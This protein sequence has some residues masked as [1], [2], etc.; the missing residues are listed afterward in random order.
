MR[1]F[2][3][4]GIVFGVNGLTPSREY[5][6][7]AQDYLEYRQR[8]DDIVSNAAQYPTNRFSGRGIV[9][10]AGG[11]RYFTNAWVC[12]NMLR[13]HG[14]NLPVQFWHLGP[15]EMTDEMRDLV[16]PLGV[17]CVDAYE[18]RK[19]HPAR[20]LNGWELKPYAI[21]HSPFAEVICLDA[22]NVPLIDPES[23]FETPEYKQTGAIFWPDYGRLAA[24]R[25]IWEIMK[26][27]YRDEPEFE[28]GQVVVDKRRCW[29]ALQITMHI[30]EWSDFYYSHIHGDKETFH[31]AWRK[32]GQEYSMPGRGIHSLAGTMCQHDFHDN[33]IFQHRNLRKWSLTE[34]NEP[35]SDF[36]YEKECLEFIEELRARWSVTDK[37]A[38]H[39]AA[40][41]LKRQIVAQRYYTYVRIGYD[42]RTIELCADGSIN[43]GPRAL[44]QKW[45]ISGPHDNLKLRVL[46]GDSAL[47]DLT[48]VGG[49]MFSGAWLEHERMPI[50]LLPVPLDTDQP[51]PRFHYR[52]GSWDPAIWHSVV[53]ANEYGFS[54]SHDSRI[55]WRGDVIDV[56][57]HIG[58]FT[59]LALT[60][61][62]ARRVFVVEPDPDNFVMLRKN[63]ADHIADGRVVAING[64]IGEVGKTLQ[65]HNNPGTNTGC[66][67][68]AENPSGTINVVSLQQLIADAN[69]P[70]LLKL[71]CEGCEY[72]ALLSDVNLGPVQEIIGEFHE[73]DT[74]NV[75]DLQAALEH[76]GYRFSYT[77]TTDNQ[78]LFSASRE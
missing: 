67:E 4:A 55:P 51:P 19:L 34:K 30:N 65:L 72:V 45:I 62:N 3:V 33:R 15:G 8:L 39:P 31:M 5:T 25:D 9:I 29:H 52:P 46:T 35:V 58:A 59:H 44:E 50:L 43:A 28:S 21:I 20:I 22:D 56:G 60:K 68:Y 18:I 48:P 38:E 57:G 17:E 42:L 73:N 71:D 77:R 10:C 7:V 70:V 27:Q 41:A 76:R 47:A 16:R 66:A 37:T 24:N 36:Q 32:L 26:I 63:L 61:L 64:G 14:C 54:D 69:A 12:V 2:T 6:A 40:A 49:G 53:S 74:R 11:P 78:G 1:N 23:L 75:S 13:K